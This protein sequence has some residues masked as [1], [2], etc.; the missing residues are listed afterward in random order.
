MDAF[1]TFFILSATKILSVSYDL[2]IPTELYGANGDFLGLRLYYDP[3]VEY[4]K[5]EK[6]A[7]CT[8]GASSI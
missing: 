5:H 2:L 6:L 1:V 3:N 8:A 4:F 7:I